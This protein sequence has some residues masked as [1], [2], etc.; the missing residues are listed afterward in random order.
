MR[1]F[2]EDLFMM[3]SRPSEAKFLQVAKILLVDFLFWPSRDRIPGVEGVKLEAGE[4]RREGQP[5]PHKGHQD[6]KI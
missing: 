5:G 3:V 6:L 1:D 4:A 2:E